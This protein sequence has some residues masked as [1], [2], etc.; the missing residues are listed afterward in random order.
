MRFDIDYS[1]IEAEI[2]QKNNMKKKNK[3]KAESELQGIQG[4]H[5]T[6]NETFF[7]FF[8][9]LDLQRCISFLTLAQPL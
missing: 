7:F 1:D 5:L 4:L 2:G 9:H 3:W 6:G 8:F